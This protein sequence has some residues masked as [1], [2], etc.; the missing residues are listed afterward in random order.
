MTDEADM[1]QDRWPTTPSPSAPSSKASDARRAGA[2]RDGGLS[3][4]DLLMV[5]AVST[6]AP[7][8]HPVVAKAEA[9]EASVGELRHGLGGDWKFRTDPYNLGEGEEWFASGHRLGDWDEI[10]VPGVWDV[11][12]DYS[13]YAGIAWYRTEFTT[14]P[15]W[16]GKRVRL[17]FEGVYNDAKVW[18]NGRVLGGNDMGYFPFHF[19]LQTLA[20]SGGLN[21]LTVMVDNRFRLGA[22]WN[23]GGIRRPVWLEI[24]DPARLEWLKIAT[25]P[26]LE[27]GTATV[28]VS[29]RASSAAD[30]DGVLGAELTITHEGV[31]LHQSPISRPASSK[32]GRHDFEFSVH[33]EREKVHLW[34]PSSP[35]LYEARVRLFRQDAPRHELIDSFGVRKVE[36]SGEKLLLNGEPVRGVGFNL[37]PEDRR[38]GSMLPPSRFRADVDRMKMLG[39][40]ITRLSHFP[41]PRDFLEYLDRKGI[42]CISEVPIWGKSELVNAASER[43][44]D[45]LERL[46]TEQYNH[47]AIIGWSV[48][49]EIG[50][51]DRNPAAGEYVRVAVG[52]AR[53]LDP[54]RLAVYASNSAS[55]QPDDPVKFTD[56]ILLNAYNADNV[57]GGIAESI[58]KTRAL[59][60]GKP[61]FLSEYGG[62]LDA[63]DPNLAKNAGDA[64]LGEMRHKPYVIGASLW[65][66]ADYRS[67]WPGWPFSPPTPPSQNR[68][69][70]VLTVDRRP[71]RSYFACRAAHAPVASMT[72]R[73]AGRSFVVTLTSRDEN[74]LPAYVMRGYRLLW[75]GLD[76]SGGPIQ[77]GLVNVP[78]LAPGGAAVQLDIK[79]ASGFVS[80]LVDLVDPL[81]YSLLTVKRD[82]EPPSAPSIRKV[83]VSNQKLRVTFDA[84][85]R[86]DEYMA[87]VRGEDGE[88]RAEPTINNF[89][90]IA[91]LKL[92][93]TYDIRL[94]ATNGAGES[95]PG[96]ARQATTSQEDLPP[97]LWS[98]QAADR[99]LFLNYSTEAIDYLYD[100]EVTSEATGLAR[101]ISVDQ[102]GVTRIPHL[103][104]GARYQVRM[105]R[106]NGL[107]NISG[108]TE[109]QAGVPR[110]AGGL[111]A[112]SAA[113]LV[114]GADGAVLLL[115]EPV[116]NAAGYEVRSGSR[117][118]IVDAAVSGS[119]FLRGFRPV[120]PITLRAIDDFGRGG[121]TAEVLTLR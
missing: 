107:G 98:I 17:V 112:P 12:N 106:R 10:A 118:I 97:V 83:H 90:E 2:R 119:A 61:I 121:A 86:A 13:D 93:K 89:I 102:P 9:A 81:G 80:L 38:T 62:G 39:A 72:L 51:F 26:D 42:L 21:Q 24:T 23:W 41:L 46:I 20:P 77:G 27:S 43:A 44:A 3:R 57:P 70:G 48:G 22:V 16:A 99:A 117:T 52:R 82:L 60:P 34:G 85:A 64:F 1:T 19:D 115:F 76:G 40:T 33:L 45:W 92:G 35:S 111:P 84:V 66:L 109:S 94:V 110:G 67:S 11:I 95:Q 108:W 63:E 6:F 101:T 73:G 65:T 54:R 78:V 8:D 100:I 75:R 50:R 96:S 68:S 105:R 28:S 25:D 59:H 36:V 7:L 114:S 15:E 58:R 56:L 116:E 18:L 55:N 14:R 79:P 104:N 88:R 53:E 4:R 113:R 69:W 29:A 5:S 91:D 32:D 87:L 74:D 71:K 31:V 37:I 30:L 103:E 120:G 49:N 47:P